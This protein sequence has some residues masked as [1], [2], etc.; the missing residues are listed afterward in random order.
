MFLI[1]MLATAGSVFAANINV[2]VDAN[3][4]GA[5][6]GL[7]WATAYGTS[8]GM[9]MALAT[10]GG[11]ITVHAAKGTYLPSNTADR[12]V[13]FVPPAN[14]TIL[15]GYPNGG[16]IR[17]V[18]AN[19]TILSGDI[20]GDD[21]V[22]LDANYDANPSQM[23]NTGAGSFTRAAYR[24][25]NSEHVVQ[26]S[27]AG[28]TL[29]G[30][31]IQSG[32]TSSDGDGAHGAGVLVQANSTINNCTFQ[33]NVAGHGSAVCFDG[34]GSVMTNCFINENSNSFGGNVSMLGQ[35]TVVVRNCLFTYN[36]GD[37]GWSSQQGDSAGIFVAGGGPAHVYVYD[38][39]F[40]HNVTDQL[41]LLGRQGVMTV[42]AQG[43]GQPLYLEAHNCV[44]TNNS[45]CASGSG[46]PGGG[47]CVTIHGSEN[48]KAY[49]LIQ[50]CLIANNRTQDWPGAGTI[51]QAEQG[52]TGIRVMLLG[53][54]T[55]VNCTVANNTADMQPTSTVKGCGIAGTYMTSFPTALPVISIKDSIVWGN[56]GPNV[57]LQKDSLG[58]PQGTVTIS[59][60][61]IDD[62]AGDP[63]NIHTGTGVITTNPQFAV[64][65]TMYNVQPTSPTIDTGDP[66][67]DYSKEGNNMFGNCNGGRVNMGW[68]G[69]SSNATKALTADMNCDGTVN[70][71]DFNVMASE[72]LQ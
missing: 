25:N 47:G 8:H 28:V 21:P 23:W 62:Q 64:S 49:G 34:G 67:S 2:Y 40:N 3:L 59:Y 61:G 32:Q 1:V 10:T 35:V 70:L 29:D 45:I 57:Q 50:N 16:G 13:S 24:L 44:M 55:I 48:A 42:R 15:G 20:D 43:S 37:G 46:T 6:D 60:S 66:A 65:D 18:T 17:N 39:V 71:V 36:T 63:N 5:G 68:T 33:Y 7:S 38:T 56:D 9:A 53:D 31:H 54:A 52:G 12:T 4:A 41:R 19:P 22:F 26:L 58:V 30:L 69:N 11:T 72:W 14:A 51:N 27:N